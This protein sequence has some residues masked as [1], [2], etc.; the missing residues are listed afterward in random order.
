MPDG[1]WILNANGSWG[2]TANWSG[3]Q[4]ANGAGFT[5][6]FTNN[7]TLTRTVTVNTLVTLGKL[8]FSDATPTHGWIIARTAPNLLTLDNLSAKPV[9]TVTNAY[10]E[11]NGVLAGTNGFR[12][13]GA[14]TLALT[15]GTNTVSGTIELAQ[16]ALT[17]GQYNSGTTNVVPNITQFDIIAGGLYFWGTGAYT[18]SR[19]IT[20]T[21]SSA[22]I[23]CQRAATL[24]LS[25]A[26]ISDFAGY[27]LAYVDAAFTTGTID[28]L[29]NFPSNALLRTDAYHAAGSAARTATFVFSHS[30]PVN[31]SRGLALYTQNATTAGVGALQVNGTAETIFSG[32]SYC[33]SSANSEA[34]QT[35]SLEG[36]NPNCSHPGRI[37]DNLSDLNSGDV[38]YSGKLALRKAG[39]G[40]WVVSGDNDYTGVTNITAGKL[41]VQSSTSLGRDTSIDGVTLE[42]TGVLEIQGGL[43]GL[44]INRALATLTLNNAAGAGVVQVTSGANE[45]R[46]AGVSLT[47]GATFNVVAGA[48]LFLNN[49]TAA[50]SGTSITKTGGGELRLASYANTYT[51]ATNI[52]EGTLTVSNL[53]NQNTPGGLGSSSMSISLTGTLKY[54]GGGQGHRTDRNIAL[55]GTSPTFNASGT[56]PVR[57]DTMSFTGTQ[58]RTLNFTGSNPDDNAIHANITNST[59]ATSVNKTGRGRWVLNGATLSH[60]GPTTV[61]AGSLGLGDVPRSLASPVALSWDSTLENGT[62]TLQASITTHGGVVRSALTGSTTVAAQG[63]ISTLYPAAESAHTGATS[64][65]ADATLRLFIDADPSQAGLGK[66]AGDSPVTVNGTLMTGARPVQAGRVRYGA[67]LTFNSGASMY[68]GGA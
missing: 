5:A 33:W 64:V 6:F 53:S 48:S 29:G 61:S 51:G 34:T 20:G 28:F 50:I 49:A 8:V 25:H 54:I 17:L 43:S 55:A 65:D 44:T 21:T 13:E 56:A 52:N 14:Q 47:S 15:T 11:M 27:I 59:G 66:A 46:S 68:I 4:I 67:N 30:Y 9:I 41:I 39:A 18:E 10:T 26:S 62:S 42:G 31:N 24:T 36:S 40:T 7:I 38:G 32:P 60:T 37:R 57:Y 35:L 19:P 58:A 12:K 3:N 63:A 45:Y 1:T 2:T 22:V 16:S 23:V